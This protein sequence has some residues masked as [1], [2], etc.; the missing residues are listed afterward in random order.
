M[1]IRDRGCISEVGLWGLAIE[2][3]TTQNGEEDSGKVSQ[4]SIRA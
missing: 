2:D 1:C 4:N 3:P